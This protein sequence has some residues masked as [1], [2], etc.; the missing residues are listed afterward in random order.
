MLGA[1]R[2]RIDPKDDI[3]LCDMWAEMGR[4]TF[5]AIVRVVQRADGQRAS[6]LAGR[7]AL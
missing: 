5:L 2:K 7:Q 1:E 3:D 6:V 4:R